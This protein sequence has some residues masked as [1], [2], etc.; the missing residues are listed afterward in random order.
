MKQ[1]IP[2]SLSE[3]RLHAIL[4][5]IGDAVIACDG[6]GRVELMNPVA[7]KLTGWKESDARGKALS[8]VFHIINEETRKKVESPVVR[9]LREGIV[10][11]LANHTLLISREGTE[12]PIADAGAPILDEEGKIA[13]VVLVFR[14]QSLE[15]KAQRAVQAARD[16]AESIIATIREP[17][18]VLDNTLDVVAANRSFYRAFQATPE[19]TLGR[20]VYDL[21]R[22]QWDIPRLRELLE[23]ILPSN[24]HFDDFEV[25]HE[26]ETI[27]TR[28]ML[29]NARR[30][31]REENRSQLIL[32]AMEDITERK[33][34]QSALQESEERFHRI[35][36]VISDYAYAFRVS[37]DKT[38]KG[39][40][41]S[42]SFRTAFGYT[43]AE[44]DARGGW[45]SLVHPEDLPA[46]RA[47]ALKVAGGSPDI[48]ETRF[49]TRTGEVRWLRDYATPV[50]DEK[51]KRV[52]RIYGAAQDITEQK[53]VEEQLRQI[54]TYATDLFYSHTTDHV[55]TYVSPQAK[56][57]LGYEPE[58]AMVRWTEFVTDH[59]VNKKGFELTERAIHTGQAQPAY[60]LQLR[61]KSGEVIWVEVH[62]APVVK[63]GKVTAIVGS[64]ADITERRNAVDALHASEQRYRMI[65]ELISDYAYAFAVEENNRLTR[66]WVTDSF[67]RITGYTPQELDE[68]GGWPILIHPDDMPIAQARANR[69]FAG[70]DDVSEFRIVRKDGEVRWLRDHARAVWDETRGR[71]INI[72]G[73]AQDITEAKKAE[74]A[75][76]ESEEW[77]RR[78]ADTTST[79]IFIYQGER[80]VYVNKATE[81]LSGYTRE[82]LLAKNFWDIVHPE[83]REIVR[84]R[85]LARQRGEAVPS[86]YEFRIIRKDGT[87]RWVDFTAGKIDWQGEA[88]GIGTAFDI[89]DRKE[90][91]LALAH[92]EARFR[93]VVENIHEALIIEDGA[94]RLLYANKEFTHI[95]GFAKEELPALTLKDYTAPESYPEVLER[96]KQRMAGLKVATE[97]EYKGK[98]K[99]GVEKW[100]E[101]RVSVLEENGK[102]IGTLSLER[103]ITERKKAEEALRENEARYRSI[104]ENLTQ[105]YYEAD[106]RGAFTYCNPGLLL[107][108]GYSEQELLGTISFR[109]VAEEHRGR[110]METYR[111][112]LEEKR[113]DVSMEFKVQTKTGRSFWVEQVT[114][115]EFDANGRFVKAT[116]IL[117]DIDERKKAEEDLRRS[118]E[119]YE[120]FFMEDLTADYISTRDGRLLACNPA[121]VRIF[122]FS[123]MQEALITNVSTLYRSPEE[124]QRLLS[125]L[126]RERKLEYY[127]MQMVKRDGTPLYIIANILG[128]F[129]EQGRLVEMQGYMFDDTNRR[130]LEGTLRQTQKLESLGTLASGI[131]HDFNNILGIVMGHASLLETVRTDARKFGQ[132]VGAITTAA[133]RGAAL[134]KQMLTFARKTEA[135]F[136]PLEVNILVKELTKMLYE[137]FPRSITIE[138]SLD[139]Q[140]PAIIGDATQIHQ[141]VLNLCVNA[142]DAMPKGGTLTLRTSQIEAAQLANRFPDLEAERYVVLTVS[143]TGMGMDEKTRSRIFEPFFTTKAPGHGTGLGLAVV[144]GIVGAHGGFIDVQSQPGKGTTFQIYFPAAQQTALDYAQSAEATAELPRGTETIL[145]VEDEE[146]LREFVETA[147]TGAGYTVILANNGQQALELYRDRTREIALVLSDMGLP[148]MSGDELARQIRQI[149]PSARFILASGFIDPH[150][151]TELAETG[152]TEFL[153]KPYTLNEILL[154]TRKI[155]DTNT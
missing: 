12:Y 139:A 79:A 99:D 73:A 32:L 104:V 31:F 64:L 70:K 127:E 132:S 17:L 78:L 137:T 107:I 76:R 102:I 20:K 25:T 35:T 153:V 30:M 38:L 82:E 27:G 71:V 88:A 45:Q 117:R 77:F 10:I 58:E 72:Y 154:K 129:D 105:A 74:Q 98:R 5:S 86:R 87:E 143:D 61:K 94:G 16:F 108:A 40:W 47:H 90:S 119:Q 59:P 149:N 11:G 28:T 15:R 120:R 14:D 134:V 91:E 125:R 118:R 4:Y 135:V 41:L 97:F 8:T 66:V 55:L 100:I 43:L 46:M 138:R 22:R 39:E 113:T 54:L 111:R 109:L 50:W 36:E 93:T 128:R 9:V 48:C 150:I 56:R 152:I 141:V 147:L 3:S 126:Q 84:Q 106:R 67:T 68:R 145:V 148:V 115:L 101:A 110:V 92:S 65:S 142:R 52:V 37:P 18:L 116:N 155:I 130:T 81:E 103:D 83:N 7:E 44:I 23:N 60:E 140:L 112:W 89:T 57:F 29:L 26:F 21:G 24:S 133:Q 63:D 34:A 13:G 19:E 136:Q 2:Q 33:K 51:E 124:R 49:L 144:H 62:E 6:K 151:K 114:H 42:E 95:F 85:G 69:L 96:H 146:P 131:A 123:S 1:K 122:G 75:R 80:F 121:Y 53:K